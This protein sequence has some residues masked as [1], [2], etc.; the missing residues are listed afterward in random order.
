MFQRH[1]VASRVLEC[2]EEL[3]GEGDPAHVFAVRLRKRPNVHV[4]LVR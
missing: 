3:C 1:R 4:D 2:L